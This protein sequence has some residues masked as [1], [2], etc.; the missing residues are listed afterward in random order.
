MPT[1][2]SEEQMA[3]R[4]ERWK[5]NSE[6]EA[7]AERLLHKLQR[8]NA[9]LETVYRS[10]VWRAWTA[11]HTVRRALAGAPSRLLKSLARGAIATGRGLAGLVGPLWLLLWTP[12]VFLRAR[13]SRS[14]ATRLEMAGKPETP[15]PRRPRVLIVMPYSIYPPDHGGAVRLY[16]LIRH[17][18]ESSEIS[19]LIFSQIGEDPVQRRELELYCR[20]VAFH[21]WAPHERRGDLWGFEPPN[22]QIFESE[23]AHRQIAEICRREKI[24][25][26]QLE[27]TELGQ[28]QTAAPPGVRVI[29]VE[30]DIAFRSLE[31]RLERRFDE[32]FP[33]GTDFGSTRMDWR[34]LVRYELAMCRRPKQIHVMSAED[35]AYL[36]R[37]L[38]DGQRRL[39]LV[40]NGVDTSHYAPDPNGPERSG[41]LIVGNFQNLPNLDAFDYFVEEIWPLLRR[42]RPEATLDVV[43]AKMPERLRRFH[44][45]DGISIIGRVPDL[46]P[47]YTNHRV[48]AVPLQA[49]SGTRLKLLETF[50]AGL[51]AV[52]TPIGAEGIAYEDGRHLLIADTPEAFAEALDRLLT[53]DGLHREIAREALEL[54]RKAYDWRPIAEANLSSYVELIGDRLRDGSEAGEKEEGAPAEITSDATAVPESKPAPEAPPADTVRPRLIE[55]VDLEGVEPGKEVLVIGVYLADQP[56]YVDDAVRVFSETSHYRVHQNWV[57][58]NG[59]PPSGRVAGVT[60]EKLFEKVPKC[61][62]LNQLVEEHDLERYEWVIVCDDDVALPEGFLDAFLTLQARLDFAIAQPARTANSHI[63]LPIVEQHPGVLARQTLWVEQGPVVSFHRSA[64]EFVFPFDLTSP[65]GWGLENVWSLEASRR[66]LAMGIVDNVPV[67][68]SLREP[69]ANY[70]REEAERGRRALLTQREHR[71][72]QECY[73][74]ERLIPLNAELELGILPLESPELPREPRISVVIPT[75]NRADLLALALESLERQTLPREAYEVIVVDDGS[76]DGSTAELCSARAE[77]LP[78]RYYRQANAG[79]AV[80]KNTGLF[81]SRAPIVLFFDDDDAADEA[82]LEEHLEAHEKFPRDGVAILGFTDWHPD[83]ELTPV[84]DYLVNVG[85]FLFSYTALD[86]EES[87]GFSFFWTGRISLKRDFTTHYGIFSQKM[88]RVEDV[89][90]GYRLMGHGLEIRYWPDAKSQMMRPITFE[91]FCARQK[92]DGRSLWTFSQL[93]PHPVVEEY[94]LV[95]GVEERWRRLEAELEPMKRAALALEKLIGTSPGEDDRELL[96]ALHELYHRAFVASKLKGVAEAKAEKVP[97]T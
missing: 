38:A 94:C 78:L 20:S 51:P 32:R 37:F 29:L 87:L 50:A 80:A 25:V 47:W 26:L 75:Y 3:G 35:G 60:V 96:E 18:S 17:L 7:Y 16:N 61:E 12:T 45:R 63:D 66:G 23:K 33:E 1:N 14:A 8:R 71:P 92:G 53:D 27:Y 56:N 42:R 68:H 73:V 90:L 15:L 52:S 69:V 79:S 62:L 39:R 54:A 30:H 46:K 70:A 48:L 41:V 55:E 59:E 93:H 58:L 21:R 19:V 2:E 36:A 86:K 49:G 44:G 40:P 77:R 64:F 57:A 97:A 34:R 81:L 31:R 67:D 95:E 91:Q 72:T 85:Q 43:G 13:L 89:E 65:M 83:L 10:K 74:V 22:R 11:Y 88:H 6:L 28:Y 4:D 76:D 9:E 84:M 24:D 5:T 82:M